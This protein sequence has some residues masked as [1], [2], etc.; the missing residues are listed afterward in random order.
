MSGFDSL[1]DDAMHRADDIIMDRM[2][3]P[4][5]FELKSGGEYHTHGIYDTELSTLPGKPDNTGNSRPLNGSF[6]HGVLTVLNARIDKNLIAGAKVQ[7]PAGEK[8]VGGVYYPD[9]TTTLIVLT[10]AGESQLPDGRGVRF[11]R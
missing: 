5:I 9:R 6:E 7:T 8:S 2:S 4:Y 1:F 11:G 3:A 10:M